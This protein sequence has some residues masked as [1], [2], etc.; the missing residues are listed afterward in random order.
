MHSL[1][2]HGCRYPQLLHKLSE[3]LTQCVTFKRCSI[4][5]CMII[6]NVELI[7]LENTIDKNLSKHRYN[8]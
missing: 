8:T 6:E 7:H 5:F 2:F 3:I 4:Q 1:P